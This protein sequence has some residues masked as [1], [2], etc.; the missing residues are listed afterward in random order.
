VPNRIQAA[1]FG[2]W[3]N[4]NARDYIEN[5]RKA[6][7]PKQVDEYVSSG[8][9]IGDYWH[10]REGLSGL[11]KIEEQAAY[12]NGLDIPVWKK[13]LLINNLTDRK[14][15]ISMEEY[16]T[17]G[18]I[19]ESDFAKDN[20][21]RYELLKRDGVTYEQYQAFD[22]S[23]KNAY[24]W[25]AKNPEKYEFIERLGYTVDDY[26]EASDDEKDAWTWAYNNPEKYEV[27]KAITGD[28]FEY[29]Q[30]KSELN[31]IGA[32]KDSSG[33]SIS[34]SR[35]EKVIDYIN[36]LDAD[37]GEKLVLFKSEYPADDTY[38]NEII[39]YLNGRDDLTYEQI[40][41]ILKELGFKVS[42]NDVTW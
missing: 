25:A 36:S 23:K 42:G 11:S 8:M 24:S 27:S 32:D 17:Y 9:T 39:D 33:K 38:N 16:A 41:T 30:Y 20:P 10:Y 1:L 22:D 18:S 13:N 28:L 4:E 26:A 5:N 37:Y 31:D 15:P 21:A 14:N 40:V 6:L 2:Q 3:A 35:K 12:I 7:S 34:G 29:R 19:A